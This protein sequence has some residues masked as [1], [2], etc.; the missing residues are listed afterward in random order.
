MEQNLLPDKHVQPPSIVIPL[1]F[2]ANPHIFKI[3]PTFH[4]MDNENAY[5]FLSEYCQVCHF[6]TEQ[7]QDPNTVYMCM[8]YL[9]MRDKAKNWILHLPAHS[10][11]NWNQLQK[12]FID[13]FFTPARTAKFHHEILHYKTRPNE[14][15]YH[16]FER[17][18]ELLCDYP[19][20][21][22]EI[23]HQVKKF[24]DSLTPKLR[25]MVSQ[26]SDYNIWKNTPVELWQI[27]EDLA[28]ES[29]TWGEP[30]MED[31]KG[32][33]SNEFAHMKGAYR[34]DEFERMQME[35]VAMKG[36]LRFNKQHLLEL[37]QFH[38]HNR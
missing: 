24:Q 6:F 23:N 21:G 18:K 16:S 33:S 7:G 20:H 27:F 29:R 17:F 30:T 25:M 1:G 13:R 32:S 26:M 4:G 3:F 28:D 5:T 2:R 12:L 35:M 15:F 38:R 8:F 22:F 34:L 14:K 37:P 19:H 36:T 9:A 11:T 31:I 10:I